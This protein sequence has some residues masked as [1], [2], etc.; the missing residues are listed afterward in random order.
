MER[1]IQQLFRRYFPA[2]LSQHKVCQRERR[3]AQS[4][5][6]CRTAALGGHV[7][8]CP[9]GHMAR[10]HYN[11]CKHR[12][13]TLCNGLLKERWLLARKAR[14]LD[15]PHYHGIFTVPHEFI[16]LWLYN[17]SQ[18]MKLLFQGTHKALMTFLSDP[19]HLGATPGIL[20]C[21]H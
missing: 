12:S 4:I 20:M 2:Y 6:A 17:R 15:C 3:A 16:P 18:F 13:C 8:A 9:D 19:K 10:V 11:S 5:M 1:C 14:L 21:F 7:E